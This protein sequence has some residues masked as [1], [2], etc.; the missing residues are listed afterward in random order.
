MPD[1]AKVLLFNSPATLVAILLKEACQYVVMQHLRKRVDPS[2]RGKPGFR[3][4]MVG[5]PEHVDLAATLSLLNARRSKDDGGR[6][7][8][9]GGRQARGQ[10]NHRG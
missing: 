5:A 2:R 3:K 7:F 4:D 8:A 6:S 1:G 9:L 10:A